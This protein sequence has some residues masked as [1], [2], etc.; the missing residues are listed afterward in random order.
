MDIP[1]AKPP[2]K[3]LGRH[4]ESVCRK[5]LFEYEMLDGEAKLAVALSGGKDS[6]ALLFFLHAISGKGFPP[7]KLY[8]LHVR[9]AFSCGAGIEWGFLKIICQKLN[10]PLIIK[11]SSI[12]EKNLSCYPCSRLRR[13]LLF[14]AAKEEGIKTIAFGHHR[15]DNAQTLLLN[16]LHKGEVTGLLPKIF[17]IDYEITIIRPLILASEEEIRQF[18]KDYGFIR[19][20][21]QCPYGQRSMRKKVDQAISHLEG[22]FPNIRQNLSHASLIYGS[23]KASSKQL[24]ESKSMHSTS[25]IGISAEPK[26]N[27]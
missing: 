14:D 7:F 24:K 4:L 5:A 8:A 26:P 13:R 2:W 21:C 1:V 16:M 18:A 6:L 3:K 11:E 12:K 10:I 22:L 20:T 9:G 27:S 19:T 25:R 23:D 15:D 17:M